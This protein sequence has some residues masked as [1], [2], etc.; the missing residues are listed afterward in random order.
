MMHWHTLISILVF[1]VAVHCFIRVVT[2]DT[3]RSQKLELANKLNT[4]MQHPG[5]RKMDYIKIAKHRNGCREMADPMS[6][7][8]DAVSLN[9]K[10]VDVFNVQEKYEEISTVLK[11]K[12]AEVIFKYK[13][14]VQ[15]FIRVCRNERKKDK[16]ADNSLESYYECFRLLL[17]K[18]H[19]MSTRFKFMT[20]ALQFISS[21]GVEA[22]P[23]SAI[24]V[25]T[26]KLTEYTSTVGPV[27][28]SMLSQNGINEQVVGFAMKT[29][30]EYFVDVITHHVYSFSHYYC[31]I[32]SHNYW[33][34]QILLEDFMSKKRHKLIPEETTM[35]QY[36][37]DEMDSFV[38]DIYGS[39]FFDLGLAH[40][41]PGNVII[42]NI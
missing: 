14:L 12:Y 21:I 1:W 4:L 10:P 15:H 29:I 7:I 28:S 26:E 31:N 27:T 18:L 6:V 30:I 41:L 2:D 24:T 33:T 35:V 20:D 38:D 42:R 16:M 11:C 13:S 17:V 37:K 40:D 32:L 22:R 23:V 9:Q 3:L 19:S 25:A 39:C 5:W 34:S 8:L 36:V